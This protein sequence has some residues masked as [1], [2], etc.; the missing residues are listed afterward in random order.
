MALYFGISCL[1]PPAT[2]VLAF[3]YDVIS[4]HNA[5]GATEAEKKDRVKKAGL[6]LRS[7]FES[8]GYARHQESVWISP[9]GPEAPTMAVLTHRIAQREGLAACL[10]SMTA[11]KLSETPLDVRAILGLMDRPAAHLDD[12]LQELIL[13]D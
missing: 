8:L 4:W 12:S 3:V 13:E 11:I 1:A 9:A 10:G 5:P 2:C 7:I 6:Q